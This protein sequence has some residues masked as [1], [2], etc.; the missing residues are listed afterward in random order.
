MAV[1]STNTTSLGY[2]QETVPG[3]IETNPIFQSIPI[4]GNALTG[5]FTTAVSA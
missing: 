2:S 3:V 5:G 4:T 1:T